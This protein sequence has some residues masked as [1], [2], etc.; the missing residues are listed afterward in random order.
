MLET[1]GLDREYLSTLSADSGLTC[2]DARGLVS[3]NV[4][5]G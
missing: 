4:A 1:A 2:R 5:N 3:L